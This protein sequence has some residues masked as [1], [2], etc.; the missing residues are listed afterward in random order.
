M[1]IN[2]LNLQADLREAEF[3]LAAKRAKAGDHQDL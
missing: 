3:H 1:P 2:L